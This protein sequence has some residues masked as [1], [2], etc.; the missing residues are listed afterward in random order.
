MRITVETYD[1]V[2]ITGRNWEDILRQMKAMNF[3]Q[4][5]TLEELMAGLAHRIKIGTGE[6][7]G[8]G[9]SEDFG[10]ELARIGYLKIMEEQTDECAF[11]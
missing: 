2:I 1:G 8:V 11:V 4:P 9:T 7:V 10:H 6:V 3:S 5:Q